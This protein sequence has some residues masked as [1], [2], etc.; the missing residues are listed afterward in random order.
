MSQP[1]NPSAVVV[2]A[3]IL[4]SICAKEPSHI[5][6]ET[7][8]ADYVAK[9]FVYYSPNAVVPEVLYVLCQK[10]QG[11]LLTAA[12][13]EKAVQAFKKQMAAISTPPG[14]DASLIDRAKEIQSGYGCS[15]S[16][17]CLYI[18]LA[19]DLAKG[20]ASELLTFDKGTVN[21]VAKH[22]PSVK[23]NLLPT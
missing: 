6:A 21:Q 22:A 12:E 13:Y 11:G 20:G 3:N 14:G 7:A 17:D 18:A 19:E 9:N 8:L 1:N 16:A 10:L 15:R 2:D 5:T 4:I 23:V